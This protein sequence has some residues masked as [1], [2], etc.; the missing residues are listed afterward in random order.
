MVIG[1]N[2]CFT[3]F[4]DLA[5]PICPDRQDRKNYR[6]NYIPQF[7]VNTHNLVKASQVNRFVVLKLHS[8]VCRTHHQDIHYSQTLIVVSDPIAGQMSAQPG[9]VGG[10]L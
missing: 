2:Q 1:I 6:T 10:C 4:W 7:E 9:D 5:R 3:C 8:A